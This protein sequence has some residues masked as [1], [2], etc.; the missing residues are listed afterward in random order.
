MKADIFIF[1]R[2]TTPT[3]ARVTDAKAVSKRKYVPVESPVSK[4]FLP[5]SQKTSDRPA[6]RFVENRPMKM[7]L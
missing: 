2:T 3:R 1:L 7:L 6:E 4:K 5:V